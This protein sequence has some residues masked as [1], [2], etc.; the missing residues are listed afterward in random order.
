[1]A[2]YAKGHKPHD[3]EAAKGGAALGRVRDFTKE[4]VEF[5]DPDEGKMEK[6]GYLTG[7]LA[8][9]DQEYAKSGAGKGTGYAG[10]TLTKRTGDKALPAIKPRT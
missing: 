4:P 7:S 10:G 1:M 6:P 3:L 9:K 8:D 2:A 5:R